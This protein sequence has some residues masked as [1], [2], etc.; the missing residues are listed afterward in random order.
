MILIF[1][2]LLRAGLSHAG[3]EKLKPYGF[4]VHA[5][6]DG[7]SNYIVYA[8]LALNKNAESLFEGYRQAVAAYGRPLRLRADM[9]FEALPIGQDMLDYR[10]PGTYLTGPSTHN[11]VGPGFL[12][13]KE[14]DRLTYYPI[15]TEDQPLASLLCIWYS[16]VHSVRFVWLLS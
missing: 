1:L 4:T 6:I 9:A 15:L 3:Y 11:Q 13:K 12:A 14:V 8:T 7:G 5:G 2:L 16:V 10:G